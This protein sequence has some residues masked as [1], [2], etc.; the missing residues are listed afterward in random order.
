M[1][2]R[3][4]KTFETRG[5]VMSERNYVVG[6]DEELADFINR[7]KLGRYIVLFAPRQTGKTIFLAEEQE[8]YSLFV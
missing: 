1:E 3:Q 7:V 8:E 6:R 2:N 5:P 4:T